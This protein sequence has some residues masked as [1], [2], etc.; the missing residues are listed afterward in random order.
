ME[1][2]LRHEDRDATLKNREKEVKRKEDELES[3]RLQVSIK[4]I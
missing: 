1:M 3:Q 4:M 2:S